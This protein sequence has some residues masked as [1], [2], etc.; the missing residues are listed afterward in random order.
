MEMRS[1]ASYFNT[2]EMAGGEAGISRFMAKVMIAQLRHGLSVEMGPSEN[3]LCVLI[4]FPV[5]ADVFGVSTAPDT[6]RLERTLRFLRSP[7]VGDSDSLV[8]NFRFLFTFAPPSSELSCVTTTAFFCLLLFMA[9]ADL[10]LL[11]FAVKKHQANF[12]QITADR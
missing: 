1:P 11:V 6:F 9:D 12:A 2:L 10:F 7:F 5:E 4:F 8:D 3:P